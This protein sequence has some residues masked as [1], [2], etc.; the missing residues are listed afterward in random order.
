MASVSS[1]PEIC[2]KIESLSFNSLNKFNSSLINP[3]PPKHITE[4]S[5]F[6]FSDFENAFK[7]IN[8]LTK[9]NGYIVHIWP[10]EGHINHCYYNYHPNFFYDIALYNNYEIE[11]FWYFSQRQTK[12]FK[13]YG[14]QNLKKPLKYNN[15]LMIFI[16][17][18]AQK[19]KLVY[20]PFGSSSLGIIYKKIRFSTP[21]KGSSLITNCYKM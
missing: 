5:F 12:I 21:R 16:D 14:G 19:N 18:L 17:K 8:N 2:L 7:N 4:K 6:K 11:G 10:F 1:L 20:R 13:T 15:K 3:L 9:Q